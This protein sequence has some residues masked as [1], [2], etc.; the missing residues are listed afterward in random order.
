MVAR[1]LQPAFAVAL[2]IGTASMIQGAEDMLDIGSRLELFVDGYLVDQMHGVVQKLHSPDRQDISLSFDRP[3]EGSVSHAVHVFKDDAVFR[4][5]YRG[6][7]AEVTWA[8]RVQCYAESTDGVHWERPVLGLYEFRGS[9]ENNILFGTELADTNLAPFKDPNPDVRDTERYKAIAAFTAEHA[10][11]DE[12]RAAVAGLVSADG[13]RWQLIQRDPIFIAPPKDRMFDAHQICFWDSNLERY[14]AYCRGWNPHR[15][16]RR[17]TSADFRKW[18]EFEYLDYGDAP[19]EHFYSCMVSQYPRAPHIYIG[20][21]K[22]F[23]PSRKAVSEHHLA[24]VSDAIFMSSRDGI[25]FDRR[26]MESWIRPGLDRCN[27]TDR[28]F[29]VAWDVI[30]TS[31]VEMSIYWVENYRHPGCRAQRGTLRPDGFVSMHAGCPGGE[32]VTKPLRF[33][34]RGLVINYATSA[35]GSVRVEIQDQNGAAIE[36]FALSDCPE[37]YGDHLERVV[38]WKN[39]GDLGPLAGR[40][41]RLRFALKDADL[42]S[43]RFQ[44]EKPPITGPAVLAADPALDFSEGRMTVEAFIYTFPPPRKK[45]WTRIMS[46]YDHSPDGAQR[47][48]EW[49]VLPDGRFRFR[50]NQPAPGTNGA[51]GDQNVDSQE[52]LAESTWIHIATVFDRPNR[53]LRLYLDGVLAGERKIPD[54]PLRPTPDQDLYLGR[55]GGADMHPFYGKLDELRFSATAREFDGPP[56]KPYSG[57]D[58]ETVALYHFDERDDDATTPNAVQGSPLQSRLRVPDDRPLSESRPGFGRAL[59]IPRPENNTR[60]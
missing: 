39:G 13:I 52:P 57:D 10:G 7:G 37:I 43:L 4:M 41:V 51:Q 53:R 48:W 54:L 44:P 6:C 34:G 35:A 25:H 24:G 58:P 15:V 11:S 12:K 56:D 60:P 14:V 59:T 22:R 3:W 42:Y 46:R 23:L 50:L 16:I 26:F 8:E 38:T 27:W 28:N 31:P 1:G 18:S 32:V 40:S 19:P 21:E 9:R 36:G 55:Y 5:Y 45:A 2:T 30:Q 49:A 47:G 29:H 20:L 33:A 17:T